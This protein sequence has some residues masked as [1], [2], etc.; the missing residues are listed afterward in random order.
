MILRTQTK[1]PF[2]DDYYFRN[3]VGREATELSAWKAR[4]GAQAAD[5]VRDIAALEARPCTRFWR[6]IFGEQGTRT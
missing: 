2:C 4:L 5:R 1:L 6:R 3:S